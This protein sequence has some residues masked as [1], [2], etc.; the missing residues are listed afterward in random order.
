MQEKVLMIIAKNVYVFLDKL[1][2]EMNMDDI[3][4]SPL[5]DLLSKVGQL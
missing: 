1:E 5:E 3:W 4:S 2:L